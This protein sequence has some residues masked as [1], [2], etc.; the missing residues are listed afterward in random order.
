MGLECDTLTSLRAERK[1]RKHG[2]YTHIR[3]TLTPHL[4][5]VGVRR[6]PCSGCRGEHP[7]ETST[8]LTVS[9]DVAQFRPSEWSH[10]SWLCVQ[11]VCGC[12]REYKYGPMCVAVCRLFV[13]IF[14]RAD[15]FELMFCSSGTLIRNSFSSFTQR[16]G[17]PDVSRVVTILTVEQHLWLHSAVINFK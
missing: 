3:N 13:C 8:Y 7:R 15:G 11:C 6:V 14:A 1:L 16:K 9:P 2:T 4:R 17:P 10:L 5:P 12:L